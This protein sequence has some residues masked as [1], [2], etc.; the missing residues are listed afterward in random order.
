MK[1]QKFHQLLRQRGLDVNQLAY[2]IDSL[3]THVSQVLN[4]IPGRG[5]HTR[6]KLFKWLLPEEIATLGWTEEYRD[7]LANRREAAIS[8][9]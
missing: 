8:S 4:N 3:P 5:G 9:T 1:N 7:W 6:R 2:F